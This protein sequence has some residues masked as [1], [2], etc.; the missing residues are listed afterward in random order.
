M[1]LFVVSKTAVVFL[2]VVRFP[3]CR[4]CA[5]RC[6]P[7]YCPF[8]CLLHCGTA[9]YRRSCCEHGFEWGAAGSF[10]LISAHFDPI[11]VLQGSPLTP[12]RPQVSARAHKI[13]VI[14]LNR[15]YSYATT[16]IL[17]DNGDLT[18]GTPPQRCAEDIRRYFDWH[19]DARH[20]CSPNQ[21]NVSMSEHAFT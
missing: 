17:S 4:S 21:R 19:L 18:L 20:R 1:S 9:R 5:V 6:F 13:A 3:A 2:D 11:R 14:V 16:A 7:S 12:A 10:R 15:R 8:S